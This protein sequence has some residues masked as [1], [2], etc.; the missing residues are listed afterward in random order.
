M[1]LFSVVAPAAA[2][3]F[4]VDEDGAQSVELASAMDPVEEMSEVLGSDGFEVAPS[5]S[6]CDGICDVGVVFMQ[7]RIVAIQLFMS[8]A[9]F[10]SMRYSIAPSAFRTKV[11]SLSGI[12]RAVVSRAS[13]IK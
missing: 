1:L 10:A 11:F 6:E 12:S 8:C 9:S 2:D 13:F 5:S 3:V 7:Y 4:A